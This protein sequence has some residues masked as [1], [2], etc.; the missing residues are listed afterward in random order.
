MLF[1]GKDLSETN[2]KLQKIK[3]SKHIQSASKTRGIFITQTVV[4]HENMLI[5]DCEEVED[6][7]SLELELCPKS[8]IKL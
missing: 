3:N 8:L 4:F 5:E 7:S 6:S 2:T 1:N